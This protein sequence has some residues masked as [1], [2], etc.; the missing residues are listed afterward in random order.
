MEDLLDLFEAI[1]K[2]HSYRGPLTTE[3]V[4]HHDLVTIVEAGI[5]AP[6]GKNGQTTQF[7][8]IDD[9]SI[10]KQ[11]NQLHPANLTMNQATAMIACI[12]DS[13]PEQIYEGYNFQL[14]DCAAA[15]ENMLLA[16]TALGYASVW[17]D[18]WLRIKNR[19]EQIA[20][21]LKIPSYKKIQ[22]ILPIGVPTEQWQQ[23]ERLSFDQRVC[24]NTYTLQKEN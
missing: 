10:I 13:Q 12:I 23:K 20:R 4:K 5:C 18:G 14:E 15:A 17:I 19:A 11:L 8:I 6:S 3:S 2:R 7:I 16:I 21:V 24:D 22:I 1:K 9:L